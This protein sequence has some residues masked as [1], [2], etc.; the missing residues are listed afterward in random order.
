MA[1]IIES[2]QS[3]PNWSSK[4]HNT[5]I[6]SK[7]YEELK[8]Q[9]LNES[10]L[11]L[12]IDLLKQ[13]ADS[14]SYG[15]F[16]EYNWGI[17]LG[18]KPTELSIVN[19]CQCKCKVCNEHVQKSDS[20]SDGAECE[21]LES[22]I[23]DKKKLFIKK[24]ISH[25]SQMIDSQTKKSFKKCVTE[26]EKNILVD[27]HP[28][29]SNQVINLIHPSM[30]SYIKGVTKTK[31][32]MNDKI[33]F[34]WL[35]A[36]FT[37]KADGAVSIDSYINNL[38]H[39]ENPKLYEVIGKIFGEFVPKFE[40]VMR[41][42]HNNGR[43]VYCK[44]LSECQV[45]V[46]LAYTVL[47]PESPKFPS[48]SWHLEGLAHEHIIATGI[49]YYEQKNITANYLRFRSTITDSSDV[50]YPQNNSEYVKTHYGYDVTDS[51]EIPCFVN[52]GRAQTKENTCLVFPNFFQHQVSEF[53]LVDATKP[54][55]R[56]ILVFFLI[57]PSV[58][59]LST[60]N[61]KEQ[62]DSISLADA[63]LFREILMFQRKYEIKDQNLFFERHWSLCEH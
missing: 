63:K 58:T 6:V 36:E 35:P 54:G 24:F 3:K 18:I 42:L 8:E 28:G 31:M 59:I 62:Q 5:Q 32:P 46:K 38:D 22:K 2:I 11:R 40:K 56:K 57:D 51:E 47:T 39:E 52:L 13:S 7:W 16:S 19:E 61:V 9:G 20:D 4:K 23:K 43:I 33:L 60:A 45:I 34:Q 53:E 37:V 17:E 21:C 12:V 44:E 1:E 50:N 30:Y 14:N 48:G 49:Y 26:L 25:N 27:Y 15:D 29:T 10:V 41:S 55:Y